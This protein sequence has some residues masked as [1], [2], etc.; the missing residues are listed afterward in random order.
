MLRVNL[1]NHFWKRMA[2]ALFSMVEIQWQLSKPRNV[3]QRTFNRN[4]W[5][6]SLG[7]FW[8]CSRALITIQILLEFSAHT[9]H[10]NIRILRRYVALIGKLISALVVTI[11]FHFQPQLAR[12]H[13]IWKAIVIYNIIYLLIFKDNWLANSHI[14]FH[15]LSVK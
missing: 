10:M 15:F 7:I 6:I 5:T 14:T 3:L 12:K 2:I 4:R 11:F 1:H 13:P 8:L 9:R